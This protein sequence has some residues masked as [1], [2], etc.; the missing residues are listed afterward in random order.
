DLNHMRTTQSLMVAT[1]L[2]VAGSIPAW[3]QKSEL[4]QL[5]EQVK[6]M[7]KTIE[8]MKQKIDD[9]EKAKAQPPPVTT[10]VVPTNAV[11]AS[12]RSYR[13]IEKVATGQQV[14]EK[15]PVTYRSTLNDPQEA[16][17]RPRDYT[18]DPTYQGFI[19]IPNT[20]ALIK[21]NPKPHLDVMTD[22]KNTNDRFRFVPAL[23][24]LEGDADA[25]G[26]RQSS[27]AANATQLRLDVRA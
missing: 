16:A 24:P 13:T 7:E 21:F 12:S 26:G 11:E 4:D 8:Q 27:V 17:S 14:S 5:K 3:A 23:F 18:L 25:G 15:S 22:N 6:A 2:L 19:P 20:P 10:T 9:L 1:A